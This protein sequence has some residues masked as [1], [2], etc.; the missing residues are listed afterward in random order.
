L[1]LCLVVSFSCK[2]TSIVEQC[3]KSYARDADFSSGKRHVRE[4]SGF[5]VSWNLPYNQCKKN[6][7][8]IGKFLD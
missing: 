2:K 4:N 6:T 7:T 5:M 1:H 3:I 8:A